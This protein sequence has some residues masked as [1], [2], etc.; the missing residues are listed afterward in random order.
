MPWYND[1]INLWR[2]I[3]F[4]IVACAIIVLLA[5]C[6]GQNVDLNPTR[7]APVCDALVGPIKYNSANPKSPR[8]AGPALAPDLK[9]RNQVGENLGC[10]A[11][12][13]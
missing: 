6:A 2:V 1:D 8:H 12:K 4:M 3:F 5:G 7:T 10:P 9:Q 13:K 11:Y